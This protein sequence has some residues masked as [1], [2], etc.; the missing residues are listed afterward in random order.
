MLNILLQII[1]DFFSLTI[2]NPSLP[3][4]A[5]EADLL[6]AEMKPSP[7]A[8]M[9][10]P[11]FP[12]TSR[13]I[14]EGSG[15]SAALGFSSLPHS[16]SSST[17][18]HHHPPCSSSSLLEPACP[19]SSSSSATPPSSSYPHY[20]SSELYAG[21]P[22]PNGSSSMFGGC[23]PGGSGLGT[24]KG[25]Q[26]ARPRSKV[27]SNAGKGVGLCARRGPDSTHAWEW[28]FAHTLSLHGFLLVVPG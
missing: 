10:F 13:K 4:A 7:E 5:S 28:S 2:C 20:Y 8:L 3:S 26:P 14:Q 15:S 18:L 27:R 12:Y 21:Y 22:N 17:P 6:S 11:S 9:S 1:Q 19:S 23:G 24:A 16:S 25:L